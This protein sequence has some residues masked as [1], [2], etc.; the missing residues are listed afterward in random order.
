M[1]QLEIQSH[2]T[3]IEEHYSL[4]KDIGPRERPAYL[5][6]TM[7]FAANT[8]S[9][10]SPLKSLDLEDLSVTISRICML[11]SIMY[12]H[13]KNNCIPILTQHWQSTSMIRMQI[14]TLKLSVIPGVNCAQCTCSLFSVIVIPRS[15]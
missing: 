4:M 13:L 12:F 15:M 8:N 10:E 5:I 9:M 11:L 2:R 14:N 1:C 3:A 6:N 7:G